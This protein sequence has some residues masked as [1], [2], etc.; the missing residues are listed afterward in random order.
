MLID[1]GAGQPPGAHGIQRFG[2]ERIHAA[3]GELVGNQRMQALYPPGHAA[4]RLS[5]GQQ[6]LDA[7]GA[8]GLLPPGEVGTVRGFVAAPQPVVGSVRCV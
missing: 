5:A 8:R 2:A 4:G 3:C 1:T 6:R 7:D